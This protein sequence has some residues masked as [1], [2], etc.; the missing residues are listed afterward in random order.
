MVEVD[1]DEGKRFVGVQGR[2]NRRLKIVREQTL[3]KQGRKGIVAAA[4]R[5]RVYCSMFSHPVSYSLRLSYATASACARAPVYP[6][7]LI[8]SAGASITAV[9]LAFK[10][11]CLAVADLVP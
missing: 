6:A 4:G 1:H 11:G 9:P 7:G 2:F 8:P 10:S 5:R 3:A